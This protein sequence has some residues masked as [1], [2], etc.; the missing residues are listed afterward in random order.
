MRR[1]P[2]IFHFVFGLKPQTE[3]FHLAF[4]L[5]IESCFRVNRPDEI[6]LYYHYE[7]YGRYWELA[8]RHV[9]T[10]QVPLD[11]F[12]GAYDYADRGIAPYRYAH[13]SD[14][15]RLER[16][17]ER[18]G[19]YA[20]LDTI[21]VNPFPAELTDQPFVLGRE[22]DVLTPSSTQPQRSLCNAL[23]M[24][25]PRAEFGQLWLDEMRRSF[26]GSWSNHSTLLPE[27]LSRQ[28]P[29]LIHIED[30]Q[31]FYKY[32]WTPAGIRTMLECLD[33]DYSAVVSM[34]L[35]SHLWWSRRRRDFSTFHAGRLTERY[36]AA[37]DTTYNLIA[38]RYLPERT[39]LGK[40]L[41]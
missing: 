30:P 22:N 23:I 19:V 7:P 28:H 9:T 14:F 32:P 11:P 13:H 5:C 31:T 38:R 8:R 36:I 29:D 12:V 20:D 10:V 25:E 15:I 1:I 18:G 34:H 21:F 27:R 6:F 26:D 41:R 33:P 16:L 3:P 40:W 37:V 4:Y 39:G 24:A 17:L 2:H 35:W